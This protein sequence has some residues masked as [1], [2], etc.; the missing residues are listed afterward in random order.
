MYIIYIQKT[1]RWTNS[2]GLIAGSSP[3]SGVAAATTMA[4]AAFLGPGMA[5]AFTCGWTRWLR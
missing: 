3:V 1:N 5:A 2:Y 4:A